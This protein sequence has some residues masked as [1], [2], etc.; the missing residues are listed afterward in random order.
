MSTW[1]IEADLVGTLTWPEKWDGEAS[2]AMLGEYE[3]AMYFKRLGAFPLPTSPQG[4]LEQIDLSRQ[5]SEGLR[6]QHPMYDQYLLP[7]IPASVTR[8][9]GLRALQHFGLMPAINALLDDPDTPVELVI[10]FRE[11]PTFERNSPSLLAMA[12]LLELTDEQLDD[13]FIYAGGV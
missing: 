1:M 2:L 12:A 7:P 11:A 5:I 4:A 6:G 13:L 10:D 8:R 3:G 9:Q